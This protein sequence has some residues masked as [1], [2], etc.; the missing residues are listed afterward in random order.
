MLKKKIEK[1]EI[2]LGTMISEFG[3]PNL[4]RIMKTGGFEFV[5]I[6][7]EH[8]PFDLTQFASMIALGNN[9]DMDVLIRIPS[10]DRGLI[11]KL[12]DMGADGFLVPMVNTAEEARKLVEYA[13]YAPLGK[14]GISTTR[15]HTNYQPPKLEE[16]MREANQKTILLAQIETLEAVENAEEIASVSGIDALIVG[17]SDLSSSLGVPGDLKSKKLLECSNR[18]VKAAK[19]QGKQCGTVSAN[20]AYLNAC[21]KMGMNIFNMG[22]EV[23]MLLKASKSSVESFWKENGEK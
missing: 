16:Y 8:G 14:R 7:G 12:L 5:I 1:S 4:L 20:V 21:R 19:S 2:V 13:K 11:T 9:I 10:I 6:D 22:S 3:C 17:P 23:G 18:V 15:A